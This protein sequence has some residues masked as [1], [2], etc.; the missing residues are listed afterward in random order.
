MFTIIIPYRM[1]TRRQQ[2]MS[3]TNTP[4]K[5]EDDDDEDNA[6][7]I[8]VRLVVVDLL[9][10]RSNFLSIFLFLSVNLK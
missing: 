5:R 9:S 3:S 7:G 10:T 6:L 4:K 2:Q 1:V 8:G